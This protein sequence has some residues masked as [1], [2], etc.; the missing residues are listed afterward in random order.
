[1]SVATFGSLFA[2]IG[3]FDLGFERAGMR[4]VWQ[5][6]R[7]EHAQ[8]VLRARFPHARVF[9]DVAAITHESAGRVDVICGGFPCQD[10]SVAGKRAGLAGERTG[11]FWEIVRIAGEL[12]PS[13]MVL[14]NVPG[15]LTS[16]G[17]RDFHAVLSALAECGFRREY[18]VLDSRYFGVAQRRRRV[19]LVLRARESRDGAGAVLFEP[20]GVRRRAAARGQAGQDY[21][22]TLRGRSARPGV[23]VPG[24]GGEDDQNLIAFDW[25]GGGDCWLNVGPRTSALSQKTTPAIFAT[26]NSGGNSG[27]FRTEPGEHLVAAALETTCGDYSRADGFTMVATPP[28]RAR[29][30]VGSMHKR[31]DDDTDTL[32]PTL[33]ASMGHHGHSSPR[34]D[35]SDPLVADVSYALRAD[36]G[37]IGQS[38]NVTMPITPTGVRRLTP[39]ECERLQ[40]F[41]DGW[42]C[43]CGEGHRGSIYCSCPDT[44]R[45]KQ[46]GNAVTV[47]VAEW[48]GRRLV[49]VAAARHG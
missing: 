46:L 4:C 7:D 8:K 35:G 6:E 41:P 10:V 42:T 25:Q 26:L 38:H 21:S 36:P 22:A 16:H 31:H 5:A 48:I 9:D 30:L 49:A 29:A 19:F 47:N 18:R 23:N 28:E 2:G 11:L 32:I 33:S 14:E 24:R 13:W 15:L 34:G 1:M 43:L 40:S 44:Q 45:Y 20:A 3:G 27:G 37:G 39:L 17:G 12:R